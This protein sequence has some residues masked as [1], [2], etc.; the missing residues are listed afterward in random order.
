[1]NFLIRETILMI[2]ERKMSISMR[3]IDNDK[4]ISFIL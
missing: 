3:Q 2:N 4:S 1:M